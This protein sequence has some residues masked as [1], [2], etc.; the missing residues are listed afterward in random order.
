MRNILAFFSIMAISAVAVAE[1]P[2]LLVTP[3]GVW[4]SEVTSSGPGPWVAQNIDVI[5]QGFGPG[6]GPGDPP[7]N[8]PPAG[9][10]ETLQV[11]SISKSGLKDKSEAMA[12]AALVSSLTKSG[13]TGDKLK[14][15]LELASP[16]LDAQLKS[17]NRITK[18]AKDVCDVTLDAKKISDALVISWQVDI[19]TVAAVAKSVHREEGAAI[20]AEALDWAVLI[21]V[22][23]MIIELLKSLGII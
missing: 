18:W 5:V 15:A 3:N 14:Q 20:E 17:A 7:P 16:I 1:K 22:I 6:N 9:D 23:T 8:D 21:Q 4:K 2:L 11:A 13:I 10:Q 12:C 19:S